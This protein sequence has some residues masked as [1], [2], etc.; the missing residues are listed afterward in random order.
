LGRPATTPVKLKDGYYLELRHKGENKGIKM[1]RDSIDHIRV[2][3][4]KYKPYYEVHFYGLVKKGKV[5][6][7]KL[8]AGIEL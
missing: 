2:S 3:I 6:D 4:R 1:R 8:P 5:V 7:N